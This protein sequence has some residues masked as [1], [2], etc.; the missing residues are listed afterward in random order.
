M[1]RKTTHS[2]GDDRLPRLSFDARGYSLAKFNGRQIR[3]GRR[4]DPQ[5]V[6]RFQQVLATWLTNGRKLPDDEKPEAR[7]TVT[8][9][10]LL[11]RYVNEFAVNYY[12]DRQGRPTST[13]RALHGVLDPLAE[14]DYGG[15]DAAQITVQVLKSIREH[16]VAKDGAR[17]TVNAA[18][19]SLRRALIW[20]CEEGL[21]PAAVVAEAKA[22][23]NLKPHRSAA[24]ET[25]PK[26]PVP[27]EVVEKVLPM[28]PRQVRGLVM[29]GW[30]TGGRMG[31]LTQL[32]TQHVDMS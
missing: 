23:G 3:F 27:W 6:V 22:L 24:R 12:N 30:L 7:E 18:I 26:K 5:T 2:G 19:G 13:L 28:L 16:W 15:L 32:R 25:E 21:V 20:G 31:E 17:K 11:H 9:R 29:L 1:A 8:L 4:D 10:V 14:G